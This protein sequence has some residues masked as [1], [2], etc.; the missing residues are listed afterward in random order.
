MNAVCPGNTKTPMVAKLP[1]TTLEKITSHIPTQ[2][3]VGPCEIDSTA[4]YI[5]QD[6]P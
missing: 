5:V 6:M 2:D 4:L 1:A 3:S